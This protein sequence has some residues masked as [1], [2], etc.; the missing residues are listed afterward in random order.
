MCPPVRARRAERL[1]NLTDEAIRACPASTRWVLATN[2]DNAYAGG[3]FQALL[4]AP[5]DADVVAFDYHSRYRRSTGPPCARFEQ[6][7]GLP[8]CKLNRCAAPSAVV[9]PAPHAALLNR[10]CF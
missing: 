7:G 8:A 10:G 9:G 2:G 1:Y 4:Q 6:L 5:A 3:F